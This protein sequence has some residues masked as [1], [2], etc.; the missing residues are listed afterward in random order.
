MERD[1]CRFFAIL[2]V[3]G[4]TASPCVGSS[5]DRWAASPGADLSSRRCLDR[6]SSIGETNSEWFV[7]I[8]S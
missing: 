8:S 3:I 6:I 5:I 7:R 2:A 1:S 4:F